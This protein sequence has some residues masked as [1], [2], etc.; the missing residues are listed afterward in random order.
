MKTTFQTALKDAM[1]ARDQVR[2][3]TIRGILSAID[4]ECLQKGTEELA[5]SVITE[6]VKRELKKRAEEKEFAEKSGR[7]EHLD[8]LRQEVAV[9]ESFLPQQLSTTELESII[10]QMKSKD[11]S[12]NMGAV[13]K[14]LKESYAGR[15]DAKAASELAKRI[16][17]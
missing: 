15:Y 12:L 3:E 9:L 14:T 13:M 10:S 1:K 4:Y 11:P 7:A 8:R 16:A 17:G 5:E 6:I 2:V